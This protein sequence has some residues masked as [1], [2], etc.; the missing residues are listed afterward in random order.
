MVAFPR[1]RP[2]KRRDGTQ[3]QNSVWM[4][5]DRPRH[6]SSRQQ[7]PQPLPRT[8]GGPQGRPLH[9]PVKRQDPAAGFSQGRAPAAPFTAVRRGDERLPKALVHRLDERPGAHVGHFH[10]QGGLADRA[11]VRHALQ[12]FR[13]A[14]TESNFFSANDAKT[15]RQGSRCRRTLF[16]SHGFIE[17]PGEAPRK[18]NSRER[19][20]TSGSRDCRAAALK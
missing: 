15:R 20:E 3:C 10:A 18:F 16:A 12:Q 2:A 13:F 7:P 14:R 5:P 9:L 4:H 17:M 6:L 1:K 19:A 11:G 8:G